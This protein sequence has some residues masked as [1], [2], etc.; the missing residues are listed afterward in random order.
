APADQ[1]MAWADLAVARAKPHGPGA[2]EIYDRGLQEQL[3]HQAEIE[4]A[5]TA[6]IVDDEL[7]LQYQPVIDLATG[8]MTSVEALVRWDRPGA[9]IQPPDSFIPVAERSNLILALDQWVLRRAC[10]QL[11]EWSSSPEL[12]T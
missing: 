4:K 12:S 2:V 7:F 11:D 9:G 10:Q 6:A 3:Q 1:V 5:L 8:R